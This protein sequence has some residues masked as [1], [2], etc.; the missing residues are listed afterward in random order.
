[1]IKPHNHVSHTLRNELEKAKWVDL[2]WDLD[3]NI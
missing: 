1:M 3:F 2:G